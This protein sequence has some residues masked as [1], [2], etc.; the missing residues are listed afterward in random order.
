MRRPVS[1]AEER[2][3]RAAADSRAAS[4]PQVRADLL[5]AAWFARRPGGMVR[6]SEIL[7]ST[8]R[9]PGA[10]DLV[11]GVLDDLRRLP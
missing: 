6:V 4:R 9:R 3:L 8:G 10:A 2:L 11:M 1:A 5:N 7:A